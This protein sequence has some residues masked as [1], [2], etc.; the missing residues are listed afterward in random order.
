MGGAVVAEP[1]D[2]ARARR[3]SLGSRASA[4]AEEL[5]ALPSVDVR[6][7][8]WLFQVLRDVVLFDDHEAQIEIPALLWPVLGKRGLSGYDAVAHRQTDAPLIEGIA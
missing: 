4:T 3:R 6:R 1:G 2:V 8:L 7:R 5:V